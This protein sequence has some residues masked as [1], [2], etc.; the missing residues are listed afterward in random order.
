[1][2]LH[3]LLHQQRG[4]TPPPLAE[5]FPPEFDPAIYRDLNSD[6]WNL[7]ESALREHFTATGEAE[8]RRANTLAT[9]EEFRDIAAKAGRILELGTPGERIFDRDDVVRFCR[10]EP[11]A[12]PDAN[13]AAANGDLSGVDG[14]YDVVANSHLLVREPDLVAHLQ[15]VEALLAEGGIYLLFIPDKR[16][17]LDHFIPETTIADVVD[18][19]LTRPAIHTAR[20]L[21]R[22]Q[23][24]TTHNDSRRH[25]AGDHGRP[26]HLDA[27]SVESALDLLADSLAGGPFVD[28]NAWQ[29]TPESFRATISLLRDLGLIGLSPVRVYPTLRESNEFWAVLAR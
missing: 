27:G 6:L 9:R 21:I 26:L 3:P 4:A 24:L 17:C 14:A 29:F 25:W 20:T 12:A 5:A 16:F 7:D 2:T 11:S 23:C 19:A 10:A 22:Q 13:V 18:A 15:Q 8:G 28:R 1:M